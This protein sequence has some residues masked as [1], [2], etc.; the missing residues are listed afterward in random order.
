MALTPSMH[1]LAEKTSTASVH[2]AH[3]ASVGVRSGIRAHLFAPGRFVFYLHHSCKYG[4]EERDSRSYVR[5]LSKSL[6]ATLFTG[7]SSIVY[8]VARYRLLSHGSPIF[9]VSMHSHRS[10]NRT[11]SLKPRSSENSDASR[12]PI[13]SQHVAHSKSVHYCRLLGGSY[14]F[15]ICDSM[16]I[17]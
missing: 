7:R 16:H 11:T 17:I 14:R 13:F 15:G 10:R 3:E 2:S 1:K 8:S 9:Y 4:P 5:L 12:R 6:P